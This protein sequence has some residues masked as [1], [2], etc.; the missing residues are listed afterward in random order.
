VS[1]YSGFGDLSSSAVISTIESCGMM[2]AIVMVKSSSSNNNNNN[3]SSSGGEVIKLVEMSSVGA[4]TGGKSIESFT[5]IKE[6]SVKD[7]HE[8]NINDEINSLNNSNNNSSS[9]YYRIKQ[10][11]MYHASPTLQHALLKQYSN[12]IQQQ[13][14]QQQQ[15]QTFK[16]KHGCVYSLILLAHT[17]LDSNSVGSSSAVLEY[18]IVDMSFCSNSDNR[19]EASIVKSK[20]IVIQKVWHFNTANN[21]NSNS[22]SYDRFAY[23]SM[24]RVLV[25]SNGKDKNTIVQIYH[26]NLNTINNINNNKNISNSVLNVPI[27]KLLNNTSNSSSKL[28]NIPSAIMTIVA[29]SSELVNVGNNNNMINSNKQSSP[30]FYELRSV[31]R[32]AQHEELIY[33]SRV[34]VTIDTSNST[35][36]LTNNE[37]DSDEKCYA[38]VQQLQLL[39]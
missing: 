10:L 2:A 12:Q 38:T 39:I 4:G 34:L 21:S 31:V 24:N 16:L 15:Q 37:Q 11:K 36:K 3:N 17:S 9:A 5:F 33:L 28:H 1:S 20:T 6:D 30:L 32:N 26:H 22:I 35:S 23:D 18:V 14:Q 29:M 25:L 19:D 27:V 13:Q 7:A 8:I